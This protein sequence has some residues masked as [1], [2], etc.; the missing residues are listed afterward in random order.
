MNQMS[1]ALGRV[2]LKYYDARCEELREAMNYFWDRLDGFPGLRPHRVNPESG[3]TMAG[4]YSPKGHYRPDELGGLSVSRFCE[5]VRAEGAR[6]RPGCNKPL[7]RHRLF[8]D[9][10]IYGHGKPT[11]IA[12]S[13]RDVRES[14]G[15]LPVSENI[16]SRLFTFERFVRMRP[17][18]ISRYADAF[19][20]V[21]ENHEELIPDDPG[22]PVD[23][24]GWASAFSP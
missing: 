13:S 10:D 12:N 21:V 15:E 19:K 16:N 8:L 22:N 18:A 24:G 14:Q 20:K 7:H 5:A 17:E 11:R 23:V 9:A 4:W 6:A 2:Q 3:S 1:A